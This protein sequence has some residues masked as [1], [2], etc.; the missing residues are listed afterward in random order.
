LEISRESSRPL[1]RHA[2]TL[3]LAGCGHDF[4]PGLRE[5]LEP[6]GFSLL[7]ADS[8][9]EV[10]PGTR[11]R[12][13]ALVILDDSAHA[14]LPVDGVSLLE[15]L[16]TGSYTSPIPVLV[17]LPAG[18]GEDVQ[19][20]TFRRGA[21]ECLVRPDSPVLYRARLLAAVRRFAPQGETPDVLTADGMTIDLRARKVSVTGRAVAVTRKEFDLLTM[22]MRRRG[23]VVYTTHLYH[24]V[25]GYGDSSP[26]DAHTVKVHVS[27]L[28]GKLGEALGRKIVNLPGLG[29]RFDG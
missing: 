26:V 1:S 20:E 12:Q 17:L 22:L 2:G 5:I 21:D 15:T 6:E 7:Q 14:A 27:S 25:W 28:R 4:I 11:A 18:S 13:P 24:S 16:K 29:Y 9:A 23:N 8:P 3:I 10:I 19:I